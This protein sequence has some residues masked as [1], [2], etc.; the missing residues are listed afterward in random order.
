MLE[1]K[2]S[3]TPL[4]STPRR[5]SAVRGLGGRVLLAVLVLLTVSGCSAR[6]LAM[7][8]MADMLAGGG[9]LFT[10]ED[11]PQLVKDALPFGLKT[12]EMILGETP[13][14]LGLLVETCKGFTLYSY[15]FVELEAERLEMT[16][17]R[18]SK[19]LRQRALKLY[20][21]ARGYCQ[22]ALEVRWPGMVERLKTDDAGAALAAAE[23]EDINLLYW[24]SLSWGATVAAGLDRPD[25]VVDMPIARALIVRCLELDETWDNGSIHE[26]M[27]ALEALPATMGGSVERARHHFERSVELSDGK[28]VGPYVAWAK[29][30]INEQDRASFEEV[31]DKALAIDVEDPSVRAD[32]LTNTVR[33]E[34][35]AL[36][37]S[38]ID[39]LFI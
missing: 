4:T 34:Q 5:P 33:Q 13:N 12:Q 37:L 9:D 2:A 1:I 26:A 19:K 22:R 32:R 7:T 35:A 23:V 16:D 28:R 27:I 31:L 3:R 11:D 18:A 6:K 8:S 25:L 36:L 10:S 24:S 20:L 38:Q 14:H 30:A 29:V 21:R 15:A 17:F 39:D